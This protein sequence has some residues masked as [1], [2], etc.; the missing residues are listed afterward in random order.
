MAYI[1]KNIGQFFN[2]TFNFDFLEVFQDVVDRIDEEDIDSTDAILESIDSTIIYTNQMW[3]ILQYYCD[4]IHA[5]W[6][7][8]YENFCTDV[9]AYVETYLKNAK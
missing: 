7:T 4:P 6:N 1:N 2:H 8:A 5:N 9:L 3:Q